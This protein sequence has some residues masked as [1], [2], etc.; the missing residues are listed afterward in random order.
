LSFSAF[1]PDL[2]Y[3]QVKRSKSFMLGPLGHYNSA[4]AFWGFSHGLAISETV[5][6]FNGRNYEALGYFDFWQSSK[7]ALLVQGETANFPLANHLDKW[8]RTGCFMHSVN[9]PLL[10]TIADIAKE[11]LSNLGLPAVA[12]AA[13]YLPDESGDGPV[14]PVFPEIGERLGIS[15]H[16]F[17]KVERGLRP[18]D[19]PVG[20]LNLAE[21]VKASFV[22]FAKHDREE[23]VCER[24]ALEAFQNFGAA[25]AT[26]VSI[27]S[28]AD[29]CARPPPVQPR[30]TP[31]SNLPTY[32]FWKTAVASIPREEVDPV[33]CVQFR[34]PKDSKIATAGSCF[35]QNIS[36]TLQRGGFNYHVTEADHSLPAEEAHRRNYG[37]Y[38]ARY[39]NLYTARQLLQLFERA[40]G[41]LIPVDKAWLREDGRYVDPFRPQIEPDGYD[42]PDAVK[43]SREHHLGAVREMFESMNVFV[44]TLGL[45]EAWR[46]KADGAVFPLAPGVAGGEVDFARYEYTNFR[47]T[48]VVEDLDRFLTRLQKVNPQA[49]TILTV[50]PVPLVATYEHKHVL[51]ATTYSKSVLRVAAN[52][53]CGRHENCAYFPSYEVITGDYARGAYFERD[54][55]TVTSGGID[56]VM[57]LFV[58][59]Y[60]GAEHLPLGNRAL[61]QELLAINDIVCDEEAIRRS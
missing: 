2:V 60:F 48:D 36:K 38:S 61:L 50:S 33:L 21:F 58:K 11:I 25:L 7:Q 56:H 44:L 19:R 5:E 39:G 31:Y 9:H 27:K 35:A 4:I 8:S 17:F 3:I 23:L 24:L 16:Y 37:V 42:S 43:I 26:Q 29:G 54:L 34:I 6:L 13:Q 59:H 32:Q 49:R 15:G 47:L 18:A 12:E 10:F 45:T 55:R 20:M 57:R 28:G 51:V 14:W 22:A 41:A 46:S 1:H 40:Y 53:I 30:H 52:D